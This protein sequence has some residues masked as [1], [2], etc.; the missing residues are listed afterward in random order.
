MDAFTLPALKKALNP[1]NYSAYPVLISRKGTGIPTFRDAVIF[2]TDSIRLRGNVAFEGMAVIQRNT[3]IDAEAGQSVC[4]GAGSVIMDYV[5]IHATTGDIH[6]GK[7]VVM[8]HGCQLMGTATM[9]DNAFM[10]IAVKVNISEPHLIIGSDTLLLPSIHIDSYDAHLFDQLAGRGNIFLHEPPR[11]IGQVDQTAVDRLNNVEAES[12]MLEG[13]LAWFSTFDFGTHYQ[14]YR[15]AYEEQVAAG[16]LDLERDS[17][18]GSPVSSFGRVARRL[19][20]GAPKG[21]TSLSV[22]NWNY[23]LFHH[24]KAAKYVIN[25]AAEYGQV[26]WDAPQLQSAAMLLELAYQITD[27]Q[28]CLSLSKA[29]AYLLGCYQADQTQHL[30]Q[31]LMKHAVIVRHALD[32]LRAH[33]RQHATIGFHEDASLSDLYLNSGAK[34]ERTLTGTDIERLVEQLEVVQTYLDDFIDRLYA[35]ADC[36]PTARQATP[37]HPA[38]YHAFRSLFY[39]NQTDIPN[40]ILIEDGPSVREYNGAVP[41]IEPHVTVAGRVDLT[42]AVRLDQGVTIANSTVRSEDPK[43]PAIIGSDAV[44]QHAI[45]HTAYKEQYVA[46]IGAECVV[47]GNLEAGKTHLHGPFI[48]DGSYIAA[49]VVIPDGAQVNGVVEANTL[50]DP[51]IAYEGDVRRYA[52]NMC[53]EA[54]AVETSDQEAFQQM[55]STRRHELRQEINALMREKVAQYG[56]IYR[57]SAQIQVGYRLLQTASKYYESL[58]VESEITEMLTDYIEAYAF[59]LGVIHDISDCAAILLLDSNQQKEAVRAIST[60]LKQIYKKSVAPVSGWPHKR[61]QF[62]RHTIMAKA[63]GVMHTALKQHPYKNLRL[64]FKPNVPYYK[65]AV[66]SLAN[67]IATLPTLLDKLGSI[68]PESGSRRVSNNPW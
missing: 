53:S 1:R 39:N 55:I 7:N 57:C 49:A 21:V 12:V 20:H 68:Q 65:V 10:N 14:A 62:D 43:V 13:E 5:T 59:M 51:D 63:G 37:Y 46:Y 61:G 38:N 19:Y 30:E 4:V 52:G 6:I 54:S 25:D 56:S 28:A 16:T 34:L 3:V 23:T 26:V 15:Q 40:L 9:Q 22:W 50:V 2:G 18:I 42:G 41:V 8:A 44:V 11:I 33:D 17:L 36:Q 67:R 35:L 27:H 32:V 58:C 60:D 66:E 48:A 45:V 47:D 64:H 24:A 31:A 29:L